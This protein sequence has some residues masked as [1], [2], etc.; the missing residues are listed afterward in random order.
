MIATKEPSNK[1]VQDYV[2]LLIFLE[3][4]DEVNGEISIYPK[5]RFNLKI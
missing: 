1:V 5:Q 2:P 3:K 4:V